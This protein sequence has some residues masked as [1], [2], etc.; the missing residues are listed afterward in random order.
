MNNINNKY[1][2]FSLNALFLIILFSSNLFAA[3]DENNINVASSKNKLFNSSA[4]NLGLNTIK[5]LGDLPSTQPQFLIY[6][7]SSQIHSGGGLIYTDPGIDLSATFFIDTNLLHRFIVGSEYLALKGR[8]IR[9]ISSYVH[10]T[11]H[12][13]VDLLNFYLGYHYSFWQTR[14]QNAKFYAGPEIMFNSVVRNQRNL[15]TLYLLF[16]D[17]NT[18]VSTQKDYDF[19]IGGRLKAGFEGRLHNNIYINVGFTVGAYN[20]LLRDKSKGELFNA[21]NSFETTESIQPFFNYL[22][23]F[24]YRFE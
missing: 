22:I 3:P 10:V 6:G 15:D 21:K 9:L 11:S 12:H 13:Y 1:Q 2:I 17:R 18:G 16:S 20:L 8:E 19:R 5:L 23:S 24:Q 7:N 4:I 14:F